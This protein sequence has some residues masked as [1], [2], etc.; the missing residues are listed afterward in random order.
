MK[1]YSYILLDWDGNLANTLDLWPNAL[2]EVMKQRG[3]N[4]SRQQL[5][6]STWGFVVYVTQQTDITSQEAAAAMAEASEIV[7]GR[8]LDVDLFPGAVETLTELGGRGKH[9]ALITTSE[10]RMVMPVLER[11][12]VAHLFEVIITDDDLNRKYRKPHPKP[13]LMALSQMG[14]APEQAIMVGDRDKDIVAGHNA[15]MDSVLFC[16]SIHR[17]H[18]NIDK[19]ME[20]KPTYVI[21]DL[22]ELS[23]LIGN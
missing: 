14:G 3:F 11:F 20:Y 8:S 10:R 22:R 5:V 16:S 13:L 19:F 7:A 18:Y 6:D 1:Q 12:N 15:G 9:L 21:S 17:Q 4:L 2:G 23:G